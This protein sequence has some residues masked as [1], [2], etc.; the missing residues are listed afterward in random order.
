MHVLDTKKLNRPR[1]LA[2][3]FMD[4]G[5]LVPDELL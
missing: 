4:Q 2:K 5:N 1:N 3:S